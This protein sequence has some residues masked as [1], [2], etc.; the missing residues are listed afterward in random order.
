MS[1]MLIAL[2]L[3]VA[4]GPVLWLVPSK[5]DRRLTALRARARAEGMLVE[6]RRLPKP[7]PTPQDRVS[8][9]GKV[10]DPVI[11]TASYGYPM[12]RKL[13]HLPTWRVVRRAVESQSAHDPLPGWSYRL[14]S[15]RRGQGLSSTDARSY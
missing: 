13:T 8:S 14:A 9:G 6:I 5:R 1:W 10:R 12:K 3:L 15:E 2:L 4:F 7:D 11:E